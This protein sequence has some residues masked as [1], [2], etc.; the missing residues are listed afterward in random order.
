VEITIT[1]PGVKPLSMPQRQKFRTSGA[2]LKKKTV[3]YAEEHCKVV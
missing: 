2:E 3:N 1:V